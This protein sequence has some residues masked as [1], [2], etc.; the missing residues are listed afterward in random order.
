MSRRNLYAL[1]TRFDQGEASEREERA[2]ASARAKLERR[3]R[4]A[5]AQ[6]EAAAQFMPDTF[7]PLPEAPLSLWTR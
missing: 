3:H 2:L 1:R 7:A 4:A 5:R 6:I